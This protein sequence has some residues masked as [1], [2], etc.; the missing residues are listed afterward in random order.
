MV[1]LRDMEPGDLPAVLDMW[2]AA[3]TPVVPEIDFEARRPSFVAH[4]AELAAGGA[5][6]RV[7]V[8]AEEPVGLLVIHP[9]T[10]YLDQIAVAPAHQGKVLSRQLL[11]DARQI[12]PGDITLTVNQL[13][14]RAIR[15]YEREGFVRGASGI[16]PTSGLPTWHYAWS[17]N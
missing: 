13:N 6:Q 17:P 8:I 9:E 15:F 1:L 12:A 16:S 7:A 11:A 2:E 4:L 3:W 5:R 14:S 10:G